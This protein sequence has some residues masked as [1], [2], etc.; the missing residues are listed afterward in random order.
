MFGYLSDR[1]LML[2]LLLPLITVGF[3]VKLGI[4]SF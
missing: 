2:L 4:M 3:M 1:T